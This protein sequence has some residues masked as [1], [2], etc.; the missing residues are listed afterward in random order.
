MI[1]KIDQ[2][3][4]WWQE[5]AKAELELFN[6]LLEVY[7]AQVELWILEFMAAGLLKDTTNDKD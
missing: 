2:E 5:K 7:K 4:E 1:T 3:A 6:I